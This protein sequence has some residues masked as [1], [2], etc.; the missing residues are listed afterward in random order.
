MSF[1]RNENHFQDNYLAELRK[2]GAYAIAV[3]G[4]LYQS[5]QPDLTITS[6]YGCDTKVELKVYRGTDMPDRESIKRLLRGAQINVITNQLW[7]RAA[8]C[9]IIAQIA[10]KPDTCCI[11]SA[12]KVSFDLWVNSCKLLSNLPWGMRS[13]YYE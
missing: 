5:G 8:H 2:N 12:H 9:L 1:G 7:R 11:V 3:V 6:K 10:E 13:P 4:G